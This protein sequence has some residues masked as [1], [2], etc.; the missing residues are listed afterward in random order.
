MCYTACCRIE[1]NGFGLKEQLENPHAFV[2]NCIS[3]GV[4]GLIM[5][6][7][8]HEWNKGYFSYEDFQE[9]V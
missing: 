8:D 5:E 6:V 9:M 3:L 7:V 4:G 2:F 1:V